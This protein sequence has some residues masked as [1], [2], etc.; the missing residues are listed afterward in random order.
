MTDEAENR[1]GNGP[2][3]PGSVQERAAEVGGNVTEAG[4]KL[5]GT[6]SEQAKRVA[7]DVERQTRDFAGEAR[8]QLL[9]QADSQLRRAVSGL[10]AV[11]QELAAISDN[12]EQSELA[13]D[14][15]NQ[16]S[17]RVRSAAD[18]L[19]V[20]EPG[21][22][23]SEVRTFAQRRPGSFLLGAAVAGLLLGR[24]TRGALAA[25]SS[26]TPK[27]EDSD[28]HGLPIS[29]ET[30]STHSTRFPATTSSTVSPRID[31][32]RATDFGPEEYL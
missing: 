23:S 20:R 15:A 22:L 8:G 6:A 12:Q 26:D 10:R 7:S 32:D 19:E 1:S 17:S 29:P 11:E 21:D 9:E 2:G 24:L 31:S 14:L 27:T 16:A 4:S 5:V 25:N 28:N 13:R 18:W 30:S 3:S